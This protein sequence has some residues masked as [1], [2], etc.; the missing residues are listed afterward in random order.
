[1]FFGNWVAYVSIIVTVGIMVFFTYVPV[2]N[3]FFGM[4]GINGIQWARVAVSMVR[5]RRAPSRA[6][7]R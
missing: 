6:R 7:C 3:A 2:V 4:T 5:T 1:M